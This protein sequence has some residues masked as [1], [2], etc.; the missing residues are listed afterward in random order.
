[1]RQYID[2]CQIEAARMTTRCASSM[3]GVTNT[4]DQSR[5]TCIVYLQNMQYCRLHYITHTFVVCDNANHFDTAVRRNVRY[6]VQ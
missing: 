5:C 2:H 6:T 1:M 3:Y 4:A